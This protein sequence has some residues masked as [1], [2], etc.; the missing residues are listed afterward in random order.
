M[1][2]PKILIVGESPT[3]R[4]VIQ[5][6][7]IKKNYHVFSVSNYNEAITIL[8]QNH[9]HLICLDWE[10]PDQGSLEF[11]R[12]LRSGWKFFDLPI[13]MVTG[14]NQSDS[15][16]KAMNVGCDDFV[17]KDDGVELLEIRIRRL[18]T[19]LKRLDISNI[20]RQIRHI[21]LVDDSPTFLV[22][23]E[24][25]LIQCH[26]EVS[27]ALSGKKA[28][29]ILNKNIIDLV[30][31]DWMM[32]EMSGIELISHIR[33]NNLFKEIPIIM[34]SGKDSIDDVVSAI[35][36]GAD[37]FIN[38]DSDLI[39]LEKKI[40]VLLRIQAQYHRYTKR[41]IED[42]KII[43][44]IVIQRTN[45]LKKTQSQLIQAEKMSSLGQMVAG[46]AHEINNPISFIH[47]NLYIL[48][49]D[50]EDILDVFEKYRLF[51]NGKL[52]KEDV[53]NFEEDINLEEILIEL[54]D[55]IERSSSGINRIRD[56]VLNLKNFARLDEGERKSV[57]IYEG[58]ENAIMILHHRLKDK[59]II[60]K[61][62]QPVPNL[63]CAA[64]K[65]N[66]VFLNL[67]TN[68]IDAIDDKGAITIYGY[69]KSNSIFLEF[70]D[71]GKGIPLDIVDKIFEPF[72]TTKPV[73]SGT[74]LGL[75]ISYNIIQEHDGSITVDSKSGKTTFIIEL[76]IK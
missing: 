63:Y 48:K 57:N 25:F 66:Q 45:E 33:Q 11:V 20:D 60:N 2:K 28:L 21:L 31:V 24:S 69:Q 6:Y 4:A 62:F 14:R 51:L 29:E 9:I 56:I 26:F 38:K 1:I 18:L 23:T 64:G 40:S 76:P 46:I 74:G 55:T 59:I 72:F 41:L 50:I 22:T 13:V 49:T 10:M 15:V 37:D 53:L 17:T 67:L 35:E 42:K 73:G 34:L 75:S 27:T 61:D 44:Q 8:N 58:I 30:V 32:P 7:L 3:Q 39:L 71:T 47:N 19:F 52:C 65:L 43:E 54:N 12:N 16:I 70:T 5:A 36:R 68:S